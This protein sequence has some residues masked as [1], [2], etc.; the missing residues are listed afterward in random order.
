MYKT[1]H[2]FPLGKVR[3][4]I[5]SLLLY[6][7][8]L[9]CH[10]ETKA[11]RYAREARE[12]T[13]QCPMAIDANTTMDS[14]TYTPSD[15]RFTYYYMVNGVADSILKANEEM[16]RQQIHDRLLNATDMIPYIQDGVSFRYVY[17]TNATGAPVLDFV[18][19]STKNGPH[20]SLPQGEGVDSVATLS[21]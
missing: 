7:V 3:A 18:Y 15:H 4:G 17:R 12:T 11:E 9:S 19:E 16:L 21:E 5:F 8:T 1:F 2:S 6:V 10:K 20:P 13:T 14:M